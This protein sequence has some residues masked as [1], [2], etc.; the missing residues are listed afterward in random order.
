MAVGE[1]VLPEFNLIKGLRIGTACAGIKKQG[2][3]DLV[4]FELAE[5]STTAGVFTLN[6]FCAAPVQVARQH[7]QAATPRYFIIN[8]GNANAGTGAL[9]LADAKQ[10]CAAVAELT[11]VTAQAVQIG[12]AHV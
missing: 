7:L 5:G 2:R 6:A 9:G 4:V 12:R 10:T 11:E 8:T 1:L 3:K